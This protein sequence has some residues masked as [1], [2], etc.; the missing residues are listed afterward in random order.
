M[1]SEESLT[2]VETSHRRTSGKSTSAT[3]TSQTSRKVQEAISRHQTKANSV[4]V[5]SSIYSVDNFQD[6]IFSFPI[7]TYLQFGPFYKVRNTWTT[8]GIRGT[9]FLKTILQK[10]SAEQQ[11][12]IYALSM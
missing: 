9:T 2:D 5:F 8:N 12:E 1:V 3:T 7:R 11:G 10:S 6:L 4:S